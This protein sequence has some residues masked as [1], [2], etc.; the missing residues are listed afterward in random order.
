MDG[1]L[2]PIVEAPRGLSFLKNPAVGFKSLFL[3]FFNT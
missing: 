3:Y 2:N 1:D